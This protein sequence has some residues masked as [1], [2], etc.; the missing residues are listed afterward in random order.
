MKPIVRKLVA[1]VVVI[2]IGA[3]VGGMVPK[4]GQSIASSAA[5]VQP[6]ESADG[7]ICDTAVYPWIPAECLRSADGRPVADVRWITAETRVDGEN[8]SVLVT[9]PV[10][11]D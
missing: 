7:S 10:L 2:G 11:V 4:V 8:T 9:T 6:V 1:S 3:V 5:T